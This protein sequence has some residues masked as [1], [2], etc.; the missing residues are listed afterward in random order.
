MGLS[1]KSWVGS[2]PKLRLYSGLELNPPSAIIRSRAPVLQREASAAVTRNVWDLEIY[3]NNLYASLNANQFAVPG[4][5][6]T[7]VNLGSFSETGVV[8]FN[9]DEFNVM[10]IAVDPARGYIYAC[11]Y[12]PTAP[13]SKVVRVDIDTFTRVDAITLGAL[14]GD[15]FSADVLI[16][17]PYLYVVC[18][19]VPTQLYRIDLNTWSIV[20]SIIFALIAEDDGQFLHEGN[21]G[22]IYISTMGLF[23]PG[24]I[25]KAS[26]NPFA[27]VGSISLVG[28]ENDGATCPMEVV[29]TKLYVGLYRGWGQPGGVARVD[30]PT[31]TRDA[32]V[33][34][35]AG[36]SYPGGLVAYGDYL[37]VV[38]QGV[39]AK[40]VRINLTTFTYETAIS[41]NAGE[42]NGRGM[43]ALFR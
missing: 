10:G 42:N 18:D 37:Y 43:V 2:S 36:V 24:A 22:N 31:F 14:P 7:R 39:P 16:I 28:V 21:D 1:H 23:A 27:R 17:E 15:F 5:G 4:S 19:E 32:T 6:L 8:F 11:C 35:P 34:F 41:F 12:N 9:A 25:L 40:L 13:P 3:Q 30:L 26:I 20:D 33:V 38:T 29:G